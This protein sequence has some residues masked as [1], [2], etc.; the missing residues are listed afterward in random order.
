M[1][2]NLFKKNQ[3]GGGNFGWLQANYYYSFNNW[4]NPKRMG[5]GSLLVINNDTINPNQGFGFHPHDN[6][7]IITIPI[8]GEL[9]HEDTI[10]NFSSVIKPGEIQVISA[11]SGMFH[12]EFNNSKTQDL[13]LFQ[14][15][16]KP[17]VFNVKPKYNQIKFDLNQ[18]FQYLISPNLPKTVSINQKAFISRLL[19]EE[20]ETFEY[21]KNNSE[22]LTAFLVVEGEIKIQDKIVEKRDILEI[23]QSNNN[24]EIFANQKSEIL[25]FE[26]SK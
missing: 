22:L 14:I 13:E 8:S 10:E 6:M 7:E 20:N 4:Y 25:I 9:L 12:S 21:K 3:R 11:G 26:I 19:L 15:W 17:D 5:F 2:V 16:I 1:Y 24:I 23:S 18:K